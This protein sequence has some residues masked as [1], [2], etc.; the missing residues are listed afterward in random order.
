MNDPKP[1][2]R[3]LKNV[4]VWAVATAHYENSPRYVVEWESGFFEAWPETEWERVQNALERN[5]QIHR[6]LGLENPQPERWT[7]V[8]VVQP[9]GEVVRF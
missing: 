1:Y 7:R 2:S 5:L 4:E 6:E 8:L 9:N 3:S